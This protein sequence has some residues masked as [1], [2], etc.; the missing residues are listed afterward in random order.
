MARRLSWLY[1]ASAS[2][3]ETPCRCQG[4]VNIACVSTPIR[5]AASQFPVSGD[6]GRNARYIYRQT[7]EAASGGAN[8]IQ[9]PETALSGYPPKHFKTM[10]A[11]PWPELSRQTD[12]IIDLAAQLQIW[13]VFGSM[14][15][16]EN[17][18][19]TS[20]VHVISSTG[21]LVGTY[22]KQRLYKREK[23]F[24]SEGDSSKIVEINGHK[25][26]FLICYDNCFPELYQPYRDAGVVLLFHSFYNAANG[27]A[28]A[29]KDLMMANLLVRSADNQMWISASNSSQRYS[30]LP[31]CIVRPDG[32][33]T[34]SRRNIAGLVMD[35]F[36]LHELG[37]NY[38]NREH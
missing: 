31:A 12:R 8:V 28:T 17:A 7:I 2:E 10:D 25:C 23:E 14:R 15:Q 9:F 37:W 35:D 27:H 1:C 38:D 5:I 13:I 19:P 4:W 36:P 30:P 26:G 3:G 20:C 11:Y 18:R 22:D 6:I 32:T 16:I 34:S 33:A 21:R 29:I 24:F